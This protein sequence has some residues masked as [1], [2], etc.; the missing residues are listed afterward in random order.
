MADLMSLEP[1]AER[2]GK[3]EHFRGDGRVRAGAVGDDD[4]GIVNHTPRTGSVHEPCGLEKEVFGLEAGKFGVVLNVQPARISQHQP[5]TLGG[6]RLARD[7]H[8]MRR[9][10]VLCFSAWSVPIFPRTPWRAT[11][12]R[13]S[14]PARQRAVGDFKLILIGEQ[15]LHAHDVAARSSEGILQSGQG[16]CVAGRR[17][18]SGAALPAQNAADRV[19]RQLQQPADLA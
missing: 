17:R 11:Q 14:D 6:H 12:P 15:L 5:G 16:L 2:A 19:T 9:G 3:G 10:V 1:E 4:T 13:C 18:G 7:H 8:A